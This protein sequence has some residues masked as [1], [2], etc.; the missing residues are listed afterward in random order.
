MMF[1]IVLLLV[2]YAGILFGTSWFVRMI[3][4]AMREG[5]DGDNFYILLIPPGII[6]L[7]SLV[8]VIML[9]REIKTKEREQ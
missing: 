7:I 1:R 5:K 6:V 4:L 9:H 8:L 2:G 3:G